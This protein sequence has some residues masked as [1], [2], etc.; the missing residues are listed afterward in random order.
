MTPTCLVRRGEQRVAGSADVSHEPRAAQQQE[1]R[2]QLRQ[3]AERVPEMVVVEG[4]EVQV[5]DAHT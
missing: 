5:A 1:Q 4:G 2:Q 3:R